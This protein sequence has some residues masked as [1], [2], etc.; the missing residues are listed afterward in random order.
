MKNPR[1]LAILAILL[2]AVAVAPSAQSLPYGISGV[3][4]SGCNCHGTT[5]SSEVVPIL[6][7]LPEELEAGATYT[8]NISFTGGPS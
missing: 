6:E 1:A 8:L 4:N 2:L 3:E 5:S 7:G